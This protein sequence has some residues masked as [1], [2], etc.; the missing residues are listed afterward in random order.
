MARTDD[1]FSSSVWSDPWIPLG[2]TR[3]PATPRGHS[4]LTKVAELISP[5]TGTWDEELVRDTFWERDADIILAMATDDNSDDWPAWH[6]NPK[7]EF[8]VKSAYKLAVKKREH[9]KARDG[10]GSNTIDRG[11]GNFD[12]KRIWKLSLPNKVRMFI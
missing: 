2:V 3:R 12:W 10:S 8:S 6:Y 9:D 5:S 11:P 1:P 4:L 7:G